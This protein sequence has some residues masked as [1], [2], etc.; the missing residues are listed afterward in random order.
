MSYA[1]CRVQKIKGASGIVGL[2]IHNERQREHSNTNPD[3][4]H[5]RSGN[6]Y[7]LISTNG[8][9]Y[10]VLADERIAEGYKGQKAIR[11]D[12]VKVC[13]IL[14]TSDTAF[15]EKSNRDRI[16]KPKEKTDKERTFFKECLSW[17]EKRF[18]K[19]NIISA[20]VHLDETTPHLHVDFVTLTS[21]GRLSA[22]EVLGGRYDL[23][24]MQDGF[25][26][27]VGKRWGMER[28]ER[29]DLDNPEAPKPVKNRTTAEYKKEARN[30]EIRIEALKGEYSGIISNLSA[31]NQE[32][33][34]LTAERD[35]AISDCM[36]VGYELQETK[37][38]LESVRLEAS[39]A[40]K[41]ANIIQ[42]RVNCLEQ[43]KEALNGNLEA[44][45]RKHEILI[46]ENEKLTKHHR[47]RTESIKALEQQEKELNIEITGLK[48]EAELLAK[49]IK[50]FKIHR[51]F[52]GN[53]IDEIGTKTLFGKYL[54]DEDD[55][56]K[57]K[58]QAKGLNASEKQVSELKHKV[59]QLEL[60]LSKRYYAYLNAKEQADRIPNLTARAVKAEKSNERMK[61]IINSSPDS[62]RS[63]E[64]AEQILIEQER[65]K[66]ERIQS[67]RENRSRGFSR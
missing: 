31:L 50:Q 5:S 47:E 24:R 7:S 14:F 55:F 38:E 9:G 39:T 28:G 35:K 57:L 53:D 27:Q 65:T 17:A 51:F 48:R 8:K 40:L 36:D 25:F 1:I 26:E 52:N 15:F 46:S 13:E 32:I 16:L 22:K 60:D 63:F 64:A 49:D 19:E 58:K 11:K 18:G 43:Q 12:A 3:I 33:T 62:K 59:N 44:I 23:Q 42:T 6:N 30:L 66:A 2:Q 34:V 4:D 56:N 41:T 20:I 67:E 37:H 54:L 45:Q 10:N 21:D 29:A 61:E